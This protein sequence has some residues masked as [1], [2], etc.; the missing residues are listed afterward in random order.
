MFLPKEEVVIKSILVKKAA[1]NNLKNINVVFPMETLTVV[2]GVSGSGK[3]TLVNDVLLR[4]LQDKCNLKNKKI[5]KK[6]VVLLFLIL[7]V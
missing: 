5:V 6:I 2:T 4:S 7:I 3:S 1:K